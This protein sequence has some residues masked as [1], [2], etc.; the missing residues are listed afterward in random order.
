MLRKEKG[1]AKGNTKEKQKGNTEVSY[2]DVYISFPLILY[3]K[4]FVKPSNSTNFGPESESLLFF[5]AVRINRIVS[6]F[7]AE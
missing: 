5:Y 1:N 7:S 3:V 4:Y 2:I 6:R